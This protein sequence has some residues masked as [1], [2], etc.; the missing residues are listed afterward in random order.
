MRLSE[1]TLIAALAVGLSAASANALTTAT[2]TNDTGGAVQGL[3]DTFNVNVT[4]GFDGGNTLTSIF[5]SAGWDPTVLSL[6]GSTAAP[7]AIF[8]G[9]SGFAAKVVDP[10]VFPGDPAG[11]IRTA[12]Y[13]SA[14]GQ[15]AGAGLDTLIT[16]LTFQVIGIPVGGLIS[17]DVVLNV[18]DGCFGAG[19][20]PC[21][22][23]DLATFGTTVN[24]VPEPGTALLM[25]LG[26]VGLGA[27][28]RR[29]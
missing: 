1:I 12:Q 13:G 11:T 15:E 29:T 20:T 14:P 2:H 4:L 5:V 3:G 22:P 28:R 8:F 26:L 27:T 16:T 6:T 24:V 10:Q 25:G 21:A 23:G 18:G 7:F 17:I 19:G 9:A